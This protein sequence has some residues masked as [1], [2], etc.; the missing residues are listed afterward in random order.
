MKTLIRTSILILATLGLMAL[1]A[2][3]AT[4]APSPHPAIPW[5]HDDLV[6]DPQ[7]L[8]DLSGVELVH[9]DDAVVP[10]DDG[11]FP[12]GGGDECA[13]CDDDDSVDEAPDDGIDEDAPDEGIDDG[14]DEG[15]VEDEETPPADSDDSGTTDDE[16]KPPVSTNE[17][18]KKLPNTGT[19]LALIGG[20]GLLVALTAFATRKALKKRMR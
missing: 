14:G 8:I 10:P 7:V 1:V 12:D 4:A 9:D 6:I 17:T 3:T 19:Q 5:D 16:Q 13:G 2:G 20:I 15:I 18:G 11:V